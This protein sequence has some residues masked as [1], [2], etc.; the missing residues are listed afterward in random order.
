MS[1]SADI[2]NIS[3]GM[4][5]SSTHLIT[6]EKIKAFAQL[7]EDYNPIHLDD[8]YAK[9]S[10]FGK[11]LA[12]GAMISSFF[13]SLFAMKLPGSGCIYVSQETKFKKPIFI[14]DIVVAKIEVISVDVER[15]RAYFSTLCYVNDEEVLNG[16]AE[17]Y[18][19]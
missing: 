2:S 14:D 9:S 6:D 13:S 15:K 17:I 8:E 12:H 11:R 10:K 4:K 19:P 18:I 16:K 1:N 3:I 7:S 5:E